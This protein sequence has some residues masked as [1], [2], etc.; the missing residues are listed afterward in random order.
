MYDCYKA[1][2][3]LKVRAEH[4][5]EENARYTNRVADPHRFNVDPDPSF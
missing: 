5:T 1:I 3:N 4:E 2:H